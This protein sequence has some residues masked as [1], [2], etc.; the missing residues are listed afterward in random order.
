[1][2]GG[3]PGALAIIDATVRL[4]PGA[5][6]DIDSAHTDSFWGGRGVSAPSYTRPPE[7]RGHRVP[8]VLLSGA[9]ADVESWRRAESERL[10]RERDEAEARARE[11]AESARAEFA[12]SLQAE[13]ARR[14]EARKQAARD[15]QERA[16]ERKRKRRDC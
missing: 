1:L 8:D 11:A 16:L 7:Y 9:H 12:R 14:A 3:E 4:L 2:S 10:T 5:I 13:D 15:E 6:S